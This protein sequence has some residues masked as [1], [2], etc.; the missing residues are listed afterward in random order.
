MFELG[1]FPRIKMWLDRARVGFSADKD[2]NPCPLRGILVVGISESGKSMAA[3]VI[4]CT[5]GLPLLKPDAGSLFD[6]YR[7][8]T[9]KNFRR[10][11]GLAAA[12]THAVSGSTSF[13]TCCRRSRA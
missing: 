12:M 11:I 10:T 4:G 9:E 7:G 3:Q 6:K 8:A 13:R 2:P 1:G 5:C